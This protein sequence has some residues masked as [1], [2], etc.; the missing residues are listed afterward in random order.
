MT[1]LMSN[2]YIQRFN[3]ILKSISSV[4]QFAEN[5]LMRNSLCRLVA[6]LLLS[7]GTF[8]YAQADVW[9]GNYSTS[10]SAAGITGSGTAA[11][12]Y[13]IDSAHKFATLGYMI[14]SNSNNALNK[15]FRLDAD[16]DLDGTNREWTFGMSNSNCF[17]GHFDGN[18]HTI[19]N[20]KMVA[21]SSQETGTWN[22]RYG[23]FCGLQGN[24]A[25]QT[26]SIKNLILNDVELVVESAGT[27]GERSGE[28]YYG[29]L[30]GKVQSYCTIENIKVNN[31]KITLGCNQATKW[32][33]GTIACIN[34]WSHAKN[35]LVTNPKFKDDGSEHTFLT[36]T[37]GNNPPTNRFSVGGVV[38]FISDDTRGTGV[39]TATDGTKVLQAN[40]ITDCAVTNADFDF[41]HFV[42]SLDNSFQNNNFSVAGV[43][44][45]HWY[46]IRMCENLFFSGK[47]KAPGAFVVPCVYIGMN[48]GWNKIVDFYDGEQMNDADRVE[49]S[50]SATW[51]Y[52]DYKI[53]L[54]DELA[55]AKTTG[56]LGTEGEADCV[57]FNFASSSVDANN[58]VTVNPTTLK[59]TN[60]NNSTARPSR[61]LLWWTCST[62]NSNKSLS[63]RWRQWDSQK[64]F[65]TW[66]PSK[67]SNWT[68]GYQA[69]F[70]EMNQ[71][72]ANTTPPVQGNYPDY[73]MFFAQGVNMHTKYMNSAAAKSFVAGLK[74]NIET[75]MGTAS[76]KVTL[77]IGERVAGEEIDE[78][79]RPTVRG[80]VD[81]NFTI[82][83]GGAN[84]SDATSY[85]WY[86]DG[87]ETGSGTS[88]SSVK[89]NFVYNQ[90]WQS[91]KGITVV[92]FGDAS[93]TLAVATTWVPI[94]RLR[95]K[96]QES[97]TTKVDAGFRTYT[98][99]LGTKSHPY[100]IGSENDLRL[101]Q[102]Q[103][104]YEANTSNEHIYLTGINNGNR[105]NLLSQMSRNTSSTAPSYQQSYY[106]MDAN[107]TMSSTQFF[108]IGP[109][110]AQV[111]SGD[112][113]SGSYRESA[114]FVGEFDGKGY[115]ISG[116]R[117][118]WHSGYSASSVYN[119]WGLFGQISK[120]N[121]YIKTGDTSASNAVVRNLIIDDIQLT[122]R[123]SNT[124]FCYNNGVAFYDGNTLRAEG[125][126][127]WANNCYI[128]TLAALV[129]ANATIENI[130]VTNAKITDEGTASAYTLGSRQFFVGGLIG[131]LRKQLTNDNG[132]LANTVIRYVSSDAD[133]NLQ[134]PKFW[135][136]GNAWEQLNY[137]VGGLIG[138]MYS[139]AADNT[140]PYPKPSIFTGKIRSYVNSADA[141]NQRAGA[142]AGPIFA[143]SA[144][145]GN[146]GTGWADFPKHF[147]GK[148]TNT[149]AFDATNMFYNYQ[150]YHSD[151][152]YHDITDTYPPVT[153]DWGDRNMKQV[154]THVSSNVYTGTG[155]GTTDYDLLEYQGVNQGIYA[156]EQDPTVTSAFND[157]S[158][159]TEEEQENL[160]NYKWTW[161]RNAASRPIVTIGEVSGLYVTAKDTYNG[162]DVTSHIIE[163]TVNSASEGER[164]Y[165]WYWKMR[166][167]SAGVWKND[168]IVIPGATS[169]TYTA[170]PSVHNQYIMV[171][172]TI[173]GESAYSEPVLIEKNQNIVATI[174][175]EEGVDPIKWIMHAKV[176]T[177]YETPMDST[178]LKNEKFVISYQ[179]YKGM[180]GSGVKLDGET[181]DY[182]NVTDDETY[183]RYCII[184]VADSTA[185]SDYR[186]ANSYTFTVSMLPANTMVVYLNPSGI[187][188]VNE[189]AAGS[190]SND[191]LSPA[192]AVK[193]WHKAYSLLRENVT[194]DDNII[195]LMSTSDRGRT[196]E[197]FYCS[198]SQAGQ[199]WASWYASYY[200]G[201][202]LRGDFNF[203]DNRGKTTYTASN[204]TP[205][206]SGWKNGD[207]WKN[208]TITGKYNGTIY[209]AV[210]EMC[211]GYDNNWCVYGDTR[212][213]NL[214]FYGSST[215]GDG[216]NN[217]DILYCF[218][219]S[220]EM[221]DS[222]VMTN[223]RR[224]SDAFGRV[225]DNADNCDFQ[226][227]GGAMNDGRFKETTVSGFDNALMEA[228]M[229]HGNKGFE[230][231]I[232][233][234]YFSAICST[235]RQN[236]NATASMIGTPNMPVK[237]TM[238]IDIDREWNEAH[239]YAYNTDA[240][241]AGSGSNNKNPMTYDVGML[242]A[243]N[244]EGS[245]YGDVDI[246]VYSGRVGRASSGNLGAIRDVSKSGT[247]YMPLNSF[248][249]RANIVIDPE[250]SRL[251]KTD[252]M[253]KNER[254]TITEIY[255]GGL[256][257]SHASDGMVLIPFYGKN[258]ITIN[259]GTLQ[260]LYRTGTSY[261]SIEKVTP[262]VFATGAGGIN[263]MYH[264]AEDV[265]STGS[266]RLPYWQTNK[267]G[268][269]T[270]YGD[271]STYSSKTGDYKVYIKCYNP[272][273]DDYTEIDPEDTETSVTINDGV[274]GTAEHPIYGIYGGGS[275]FV[276]TD[277]LPSSA[278]YPNYRSGNMYAKKDA[279]HPVA[280]LT[281]NGGE[282]Y[283]KEGIFAGGR[284]TDYYFKTA[285]SNA[286]DDTKP[287]YHGNYTALG[288]VYGDVVMNITGG[289]FHDNG[290]TYI[291]N[292]Y[293]GG[294]GFGD[295]RYS[296]AGKYTTLKDMARIYGTTT[297]N[298]TGGTFEGNVYGG[299]AIANTGY[300][301]SDNALMTPEI[302]HYGSS[303]KNAVNLNI[304]GAI[305]KGKVFG[306][307]Q[308]KTNVEVT[309][310]P[311]SIGNI[312]GN[313]SLVIDNDII[314][315]DIYGG[316]EK[317]DVYGNVTASISN[318]GIAGD[319]YGGGMGV[320][321]GEPATV[322]ASADIKG[323]TTITLGAGSYFIDEDFNADYSTPHY[324]YGGGNLASIIGLYNDGN[325]NE[326]STIAN[327]VRAKS[328]GNTTV[329]I[330]N[331]VGTGQLTV[332]G[333]GLGANTYCNMTK[334]NINS[335]KTVNDDSKV[336]G[337]KEVYG[338]GNEGTVFTST[339][340][341]MN[342]GQVL[343]NV[344]GGGN[345]APVGTLANGAFEPFGTMVS[346]ANT[347]AKIYGNIYGGG[348]QANVE[349]TSQVSVSAGTFAGE[350]FGGGKGVLADKDN[351]SKSADVIGQTAVYVNGAH[352]IWDQLWDETAQDFIK[353]DGKTT[354]GDIAT[355]FI[356]MNDGTPIF[357]NNHNIYGGGEYASVVTDTARVEVTNGAVPSD[358]IKKTVWKNAFTDNANPHFY[359]FGGGYGA[360]TQ[361]KS[362]DVTVGVEGY[363]SDDEDEST[364]Q[365]WSLDL[366]FEGENRETAVNEDEIQI[367]GNN[368]G[369]GGYTILGVI[370]G[371]Y[372]GLVKGDT[373]VKLGGTTFVHRV[374]GGGYGQLEAYNNLD[375]AT[376]LDNQTNQTNSIIT[377][378][379]TREQLGEV[380]GNT[381]VLVS[382][383]EPDSKGRTGGVYGDVFGGGAGVE[384]TSDKGDYTDYTQMGQVLGVTRVDVTENARV[385][386]NV[387]GGGDVANV[388]NS[389]APQDSVTIVKVRG[390]DV[391]GDVF[392]GG[393]GR[394]G[395]KANDYTQLGNVYGN[396]YV[397]L[398][399]SVKTVDAENITISPNIWG[400]VYGGGEVGDVKQTSG[401]RGDAFV[402]IDGGNVGGDVYG[403]GYGDIDKDGFLSSAD[404][405]GNTNVIVNGGSFLWKQAA[406]L[407]GNIK[408]LVESQI[409]RETAL[410]IIAARK[411]GEPSAELESLKE[412]YK[413][414][415]DYDNNQFIRDHNL[416]GGGNTVSAVTGNANIT[417][418]HG[419]L[420]DDIAYFDDKIWN[421][422][423]L[424]TQLV[425][426]NNSHPQF[427]VF[428]GGYGINT[429]IGIDTNVKV[430]VGK[431]SETYA[432]KAAD[433]ATWNSLFNETNG[434]WKTEYD[435][436][437]EQ[438]K[439]AYY[440]GT[441]GS[442]GLFR[443]TTVRLANL[444]SMPN[445]TFM[446]IVGGGMAG[447]VNGDAH[448]DVSDQSMCQNIIGGGIG[449]EPASVGVTP[450]GT[451][452]Y[453]Q[454]GGSA[455]VNIT[456]AIVA[457]NVYG[458]GAG[459]ESYWK[460]DSYVDFPLIGAVDKTTSVTIDGTPSSTIIFG[461]VYGGGD[462]ADVTNSASAT[463]ASEVT[464]QGGCVYQQVFAGGS[465]RIASEC[466][467]YTL[468][469]KVYGNTK[470]TI[471]N[472][473][474]S[475]WLWN[476]VYGGGSYGSVT[477]NTTV[478]IKGGHLGYNIF[479]AGLGD[480][481]TLSD[482]TESITTSY[483]GTEASPKSSTINVSGGEWCL[484]QMWDLENK[485]WVARTGLT[486]A[487][488]D[489]DAKKFKINHNIYGG[490]N[491]ASKVWGNATINMNKS[492]LKGATNLGHDDVGRTATSL[493]ASTEWKEVYNKVGSFHFCLIGGGYGE[494]TEVTG[495]TTVNVNIPAASPG[496]AISA[497]FIESA[498]DKLKEDMYTLFK[499]EQAIMDVIGGGYN[500]KVGG[501]TQV[502]ISGDPFIRRVFGGSFYADIV[503][504]TEV[505]ITSACV[506]DIFAGGMMGD[507]KHN[508]TLN[509]GTDGAATNSKILICHDVYGGNDVSGQIDGQITVDIRG[510]KIY[511]N[512]Y[513]AGNGN[514]LYRL[515]EHRQKVTTVEDYEYDNTDYGLVYEVPRRSE[516]MEGSAAS[517]SEAARLVNINSFRPQAQYIDLSIAGASG[518][519]AVPGDEVA[520]VKVLGKV[521]G[522]G[523]TAT[524]TQLDGTN[525]PA[526]SVNI[527]NYV[528]ANQ[529]FMGSDGDAMFDESSTGLLAKFMTINDVKLPNEINW[530]GDP[531]NKAIP[532]K[533]LPLEL[534]DRVKT[535]PHI[536]DLYFQP[537][538]MSVQPVLKWNGTVG[539]TSSNPTVTET[540]IGSFFCG[541]NRGNMDVTPDSNG[542]AVDYIFPNG[543][544]IKDKIVGGCNNANYKNT[545]LGL[546]HE[547][548]YL[549]GK[550]ATAEA[551]I[552]LKV[553]EDCIIRPY[554]ATNESTTYTGGNIYGGCYETGTIN[555]DIQLDVLA[556][557]LK[558]VGVDKLAATDEEKICV[559]SVF[560]AGNGVESYVYGNV[561]VNFGSKDVACSPGTS[562]SQQ[563]A[564]LDIPFEGSNANKVTDTY[565]TTFNDEGTSANSIYGGGEKGKVVGNTVVKILNGHVAGDVCGGSYAGV[566]HGSTH[567]FVGYPDYYKVLKSGEYLVKRADKAVDNNALRNFDGS[568]AIKDTIRLV[569]GDFIAP[570]VWDSV[571]AV[572]SPVTGATAQNIADSKGTYFQLQSPA[573]P[574][575]S[576]VHILIDEGVYGG[577]YELN[578]GYTGTGGVGTY[579]IR[580]YTSDMNV[581]N[582]STIDDNDP[583]YN[584]STIG[585]GGNTTV[586][587]W[588]D[589]YASTGADHEHITIS[590]ES[591]EGGLY[592]DGHMSYSE[593]FRAGE[594][595]GYG[596][597]NHRVVAVG[598]GATEVN[599]AK[600]MN[601]I[602][603][604][605]IMRLTD[606]CLILNGARDYTV[607]AVSTTPYSISR[608]GELQM[609]SG[610][611]DSGTLTTDSTTIGYRNYVGLT[612]NI[613]FVGAIKSNVSFDADYHNAKGAKTGGTSYRTKKKEYIDTWYRAYPNGL[614]DEN[615]DD[616]KN[617]TVD[618]Q[619]LY[620][621][622][623]S[624]FEERNSATAKNMIGL[625]SGYAMKVQNTRTKDAVGTDSLFYGPI[626]GVIEM[627][628][629]LPIADEG[630]GYV[631]AD[632]VHD[633][634]DYFLESTGNFVFPIQA[635]KAHF[636]VD[637]CLLK[638][639][640]ELDGTN[641]DISA[642]THGAKDAHDS[643]MHYWF[644]AGV[645]YIYN[646][647]ITG[648]TY[649]SSSKPITFHADTSD[650]LTIFEGAE[651]N[652]ANALKIESVT[653][654]TNEDCDFNDA[655][656]CDILNG[657][658][659]YGL[660]ISASYSRYTEE[661]EDVENGKA[662]V[663]DVK[664]LYNEDGLFADIKRSD[665]TGE[666]VMRYTGDAPSFVD[667]KFAICLVDSVDNASKNT[668]G[669][670]AAEY[671]D[672][673]FAQPDTVKI[674]MKS[675]TGYDK[676]YEVNLIIKYVKGPSHTGNISI[677]N[678][679][680][681]GE[682]VK[683]NKGVTID[684]DEAFAQ[685]GEFLHIGQL[686]AA[687][688]DFASGYLTYDA[689]GATTSESLKGK[690]YSD[691]AGK[692]LMIPAYYFMNGYGVQ[693]VY[694]CN[695]MDSNGIPVEFPVDMQ[696]D[697]SGHVSDTLVVHNYHRMDPHPAGT[698]PVDLHL[699]EAVTRAKAE[700]AFAQPRI[701]LSDAKDMQAFQQWVDTV[702][703]SISKMKLSGYADSLTVPT[704]GE[705]AQFY[706]QNNITVQQELE[707][708]D[709]YYKTPTQFAGTLN[710]DG[711]SVNGIT[712]NL[713]GTL[714]GKVYNLGL[715]SGSI[716][717]SVTG[718][719]KIRTSFEYE[720]HLVYNLDGNSEE[721]KEADFND[722]KVAYNLNQYYLEARKY[723][724]EQGEEPASPAIA[725][726][727][728][729]AG[730]EAVKYV[731]DYYANGDYQYARQY[732]AT[733]AS[734]YLRTNDRAHYAEDVLTS[735]DTYETYHNTAHTVDASRAV[736]VEEQGNYKPLFNA[737]KIATASSAAVAKNDYIFFG[738]GLQETPETYPSA[739]A[740]HTV[741]NMSNRVYRASGFYQTKVD[742]GFHFNANH[743]KA[744]DTW[745]HN[746][747]TTAIDF[748]GKRDAEN[749]ADAGV[750][751]PSAGW[752]EA[753]SQKVFYAPAVD[754]P[755]ESNS[756]QINAE[757]TKNLL[758]Y[759]P[760][761]TGMT[762]YSMAKLA[763]AKLRYNENTYE[764]DI[765]GHQIQLKSGNYKA[766]RLHLVDM[767]DFNAPIQFAAD[768]AWY[769]RDPETETGYVN[770]AGRAWSSIS[771]PYTVQKAS[772]SV[773]LDRVKDAYDNGKI[774]AQKDITYFYGATD[775]PADFTVRKRTVLG[776]EFWLRRLTEVS[777]NKATFKR[778]VYGIDGRSEESNAVSEV[779][780]SF[781]AYTPFIVSFPGDWFY[782]FNM[783][784]QS[785]AFEAADATIAVTDDNVGAKKTTAGSYSY[786][787]A[788]LNNSGE[789]GAYAIE[790]T[791]N[792]DRF[793]N[794]A[795]IYPFRG[796]LT[797]SD[798]PLAGNSMD[799]DFN[800]QS[801]IS[802]G[803]YILIGDDLSKLEDVLDGDI[804][805]D[806]DGGIS[807]PSG[808]CVYGVGTRLVVVSD[809]ATTL[810]V[811]TSTGALV[812][813]LDVR[814]G[815]A[816]YSGFAQGIY[817]VD[818]KKIRL[819]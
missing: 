591:A 768:T 122:H 215:D 482:G 138:R 247:Y 106:E 724:K 207:M 102:E 126:N 421:L 282:F 190:D 9:D 746:P 360:F 408:T 146:N 22:G 36:Q 420:N 199:S 41:H 563:P 237:C 615:S 517:S 78:E 65:D 403:A 509:I 233:S 127:N 208:V 807:T 809:Y 343:G 29:I 735:Y 561:T 444:F 434:V 474:S 388:V 409:D 662:K 413:D 242:L 442:N 510:G 399:D 380:G 500:G 47:I 73:Y 815:T 682:Y 261:P 430:Q 355:R 798:T 229:P 508:A 557:M 777:G 696:V 290:S 458:G 519:P 702:G 811:Y 600:V 271:W 705:Y 150:H 294:L 97:C 774:G 753:N 252:G 564:S 389:A 692:Y 156:S 432:S 213:K 155:T 140:L 59:R 797:T 371:G 552:K 361:V 71:T 637:D 588:E 182:L 655:D 535:F 487:Q 802:N 60:R 565:D 587:V 709:L 111:Y 643:E 505:N 785:I 289:T 214:T 641:H 220:V 470:V 625:S 303:L 34:G 530:S 677:A 93:D 183:I 265:S 748:T 31:P 794:N 787:G 781:T 757:V 91:G 119:L 531:Y 779:N 551:M 381:R 375:A 711:Y 339:S 719:G 750:T 147:L 117:Q 330:N 204:Y 511:H 762:S 326:T 387:Y 44:G 812:R 395:A 604:L 260:V 674:V 449:I 133:I 660:K 79:K 48:N 306:A 299:G 148:T 545:N 164:T 189:G 256:G 359:V 94:Y 492:L 100:L 472:A 176:A 624:T 344:F 212:F 739:I 346:L 747:K 599:A 648:Y 12:P 50:R 706:L 226:I 438:V 401:T 788:Y 715:P 732:N 471:Q 1:R 463:T 238:N 652:G 4:S 786:Y 771:L 152:A 461:K 230:I 497:A 398:K 184:T 52:G 186:A 19:S 200:S 653:W 54:S 524:V 221:G 269:V 386:G 426:D 541:G 11:S 337:L 493:F 195:V 590:Q 145:S 634:K 251:A 423:S 5:R 721:Y 193:S 602:Q 710:G 496:D 392:G 376:R 773:G 792:G 96:D 205:G 616:Y 537:V 315:G 280:S 573:A 618:A 731:A 181:H 151:G 159:L 459:V 206:Y 365:Q 118:E 293:G 332:Y 27:T 336:I 245:M 144:Y 390:G 165:Q 586:L 244:H 3:N 135:N 180:V 649:D 267:A 130:A 412:N 720:K 329:H 162:D 422:S 559:G 744:I 632:N 385:Y 66:D 791:G 49:K 321:S 582:S 647:H 619:G 419:M 640:D 743:E 353:W 302:S 142:M 379:R 115:T 309:Q 362:T 367:F 679:A 614:I 486:S 799:L 319:I 454:V 170:T 8:S 281:I 90:G 191:G 310:A 818:R 429:T 234:G 53:G 736:N 800:V 218:Y 490:G 216:G 518:S 99:D 576:N 583:L 697:G 188:S 793:D 708:A 473:T 819:R 763:D 672:K 676:T 617:M 174:S 341:S 308:G 286:G 483:V 107:V 452:T 516:L 173:N 372:A 712:G 717:G 24:N 435:D 726:V 166:S 462:I 620:Q 84:A 609:I 488:F 243:G 80:Y 116:V 527:G 689:S 124:S 316:A 447:R 88:L 579:T 593:G 114:A 56:H 134:Y 21:R 681:P 456:G 194:W 489:D 149:A 17:R 424:L 543:L 45:S 574:T 98:Y 203:T 741:G 335:F 400:N 259:G 314:G 223:F 327:I 605:D 623:K 658:K 536:I 533:Y 300:G 772:L 468:L 264:V 805:R 675:G 627:K 351:V 448:V 103:M 377:T 566:Q 425:T 42:H 231:N 789:A 125:S 523:N 628:L 253:T 225:G 592:G 370:G 81:H 701:Y 274:F 810:P 467:N 334:I 18:G 313:V 333:A 633:D 416:Y 232:K 374:Y 577:G 406:E 396:T 407:D 196:S 642:G 686:N 272:D 684:A 67:E 397:V 661:D 304:S 501:N 450:E 603:R 749:I 322:K 698:N 596:Y 209:P 767:E 534:D 580:K 816:T 154:A 287:A 110:C 556:N 338:G 547:G 123:T 765:L 808:L 667:P 373:D 320:V 639:F 515:N 263:G 644:L 268:N 228:H 477:G 738:Q 610:I 57:Y 755:S 262:G 278:T 85:K 514:Y 598:G 481:R 451:E 16:I 51:Y 476:R 645:H 441:S 402:S 594:L 555:G 484:S 250:K 168:T 382:L 236:T 417:V 597:A 415:F 540:Y 544:T 733:T 756:I 273:T 569:A 404:V 112:G 239:K 257:R 109:N 502:N 722:G 38:G 716:A 562:T 43:V 39:A 248:M 678:C 778:P 659:K 222:L 394:I 179:W 480:V 520:R 784:G 460:G 128:G 383:S 311:D 766:D 201:T 384:S 690:I 504:N 25:N 283:C 301:G 479:G 89:P 498:T 171:C 288:Q 693:Y 630:G 297:V 782:E 202:T 761:T 325:G 161:S 589:D 631:Y 240:T 688:T 2:I 318:S 465:G 92:A 258:S 7:V 656:G 560:G 776:H 646:L 63:G 255:G 358:L 227:F 364:N 568:K 246:N 393:K 759:T 345:L 20:V 86:V 342:G 217:Y 295:V 680:L 104:L 192:T 296:N 700:P 538:E 740:S 495:N 728:T 101:M 418:N 312:Y 249:G 157:I 185:H 61:T 453:G 606:N 730:Q 751:V 485:R 350:I 279:N 685:N 754:M 331:G 270:L 567:V 503:G 611:N 803:D 76:K 522:G 428:G 340:V 585:Y 141:A 136:A 254:V 558:G 499:S 292:I 132:S 814:P 725:K 507:V 143:Y 608:V 163:A 783:T 440:G 446:N 35:I 584:N 613:H 769:I 650:G 64:P 158:G 82:T 553:A 691:P 10:W 578:S 742:Q 6:V 276:S 806:P 235:Y 595:K 224:A 542:N 532:L 549:L 153:T 548:G 291:G 466:K 32:N 105:M 411:S 391:F 687:R 638:K 572:K 795:P 526:V 74:G 494:H 198:A 366:P 23:L 654:K 210:I 378:N 775:N 405:E 55:T 657:S 554:S 636:V 607:N 298:I 178:A 663:G 550:R 172:A 813:V 546:E 694:T 707:N 427:S 72:A 28:R 581:N 570:C 704:A 525:K 760:D 95:V 455:T 40:Y 15:Y 285:R 469:G 529:V 695:N 437:N 58:Y 433:Q 219:N 363:Y 671:F 770:E 33:V 745:I 356:R 307:A 673:H 160:E 323:N 139:N 37:T 121:R 177:D 62:Y 723:L 668:E 718:E 790:R 368:Y 167:E 571:Y 410:A 445:H 513:G 354:T 737:A 780:R 369:I 328:D 113:S 431:E 175:K 108:P 275:G 305:V 443:Y 46:P 137:L 817:I 120:E 464:I 506:D 68:D 129:G 796:Y 357:L 277:I 651:G 83:P 734:E 131:V 87:V 683:I 801:S 197:G 475:P 317:G 491:A 436:L 621:A 347:N 665:N 714:T 727:G 70:P 169:A 69:I 211:G 77:T 758:I 241:S 729:L 75:A 626:E 14:Q 439:D 414:V 13:V 528:T 752:L 699:A 26:A 764:D 622:A 284:G 187:S 457:G 521:F 266:Q 349:G 512:V 635:K 601:T 669:L 575:W 348:N 804:E 612:N 670:T 324:V 664:T 629:I 352:V 703:V 478:D 666:Q 713:F 539:N 30:V